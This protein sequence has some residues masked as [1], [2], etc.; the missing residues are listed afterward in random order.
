MKHKR[1]IDTNL[2]ALRE[3]TQTRTLIA[4]IDRIVQIINA[5]IA[6]E[7]ERTHVL[8]RSQADYPVLARGLATRRDNLLKTIAALEQRME[9]LQTEL[10]WEQA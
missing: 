8:D 1:R 6:A 7:E 9:R 5:E 3:A 4:D 2:V 10:V